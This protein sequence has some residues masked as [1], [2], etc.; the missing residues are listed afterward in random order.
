MVFDLALAA[1]AGSRARHRW[2]R[3]S[4]RTIRAMLR[5]VTVREARLED[6]DAIARVIATVADEGLIATE[7]P[8][9]LAAR[10]QAFRQMIEAEGP[11]ALWVL[12]EDGCVIGNA[13]VTRPPL[14]ASSHS[15]WRSSP[16][17]AGGA[18]VVRCWR[19]SSS[20]L[21]PLER[22]S[23]SLRCGPTTHPRSAYTPR[24]GSRGGSPSRP[25]SPS[26]RLAPFRAPDGPPT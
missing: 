6:T 7:P 23:S 21:A 1:R 2:R 9:D 11:E 15:G 19:R 25:L 10:A 14:P 13:G 26:R 20:T 3:C 17:R 16:K 18:A 22:T 8:V 24:L 4:S 12:E 5:G